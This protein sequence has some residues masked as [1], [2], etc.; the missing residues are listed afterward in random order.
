MGVDAVMYVANTGPELSSGSV[1]GLAVR[2]HGAFGGLVRV[3]RPGGWCGERGRHAIEIDLLDLYGIRSDNQELADAQLLEVYLSGRYHGVHYER[4]HLPD[5][6]AIADWPTANIHGAVIFYGGDSG[7]GIDRLD[8]ERR[9]ELLA[10]FHKA[11]NE[12]YRHDT[13][14][15]QTITPLCSFCG[16]PFNRYGWGGRDM[17]WGKYACHGCGDVAIVE[18]NTERRLSRNEL[19]D[20]EK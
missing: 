20:N 3:V 10:H 4:G 18:G 6:L 11:G 14:S 2:L 7:E 16:V 1:R 13:G 9:V 19:R 12:P 5:Y 17:D 15:P 8:N